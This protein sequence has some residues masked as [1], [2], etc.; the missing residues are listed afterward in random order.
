LQECAEVLKVDE[1]RSLK[2]ARENEETRG[3]SEAE[4][5]EEV[6]GGRYRKPVHITT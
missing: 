1:S 6:R 2:R 4:L 3:R 5:T